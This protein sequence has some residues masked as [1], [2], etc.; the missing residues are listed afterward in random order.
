LG[1]GSGKSE[2]LV[3]VWKRYSERSLPQK[4]GIGRPGTKEKKRGR[5]QGEAEGAHL[6]KVCPGPSSAAKE[7]ASRAGLSRGRSGLEENGAEPN[8][9]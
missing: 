3:K 1:G 9:K 8:S 7:K 5:N 6:H 2:A 4:G